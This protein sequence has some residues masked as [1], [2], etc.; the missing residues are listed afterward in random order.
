MPVGHDVARIALVP[1][2]VLSVLPCFRVIFRYF[3]HNESRGRSFQDWQAV[4]KDCRP[5]RGGESNISCRVSFHLPAGISA[6]RINI[7]HYKE[8][9]HQ[10]CTCT[11]FLQNCNKKVPEA[12]LLQDFICFQSEFAQRT[13]LQKVNIWIFQAFQL[14]NISLRTFNICPCKALKRN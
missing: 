10:L 11:C 3:K 13:F 14:I 1:C 12:V 5:R 8:P 6:S 4:G 2:E 9:I 7:S